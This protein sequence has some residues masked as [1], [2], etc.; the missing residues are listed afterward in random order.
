MVLL[1][2]GDVLFLVFRIGLAQRSSCVSALPLAICVIMATRFA[3]NVRDAFSFFY[4]L[5]LCDCASKSGKKMP[6]VLGA[7]YKMGWAFTPFGYATEIPVQGV[8]TDFIPP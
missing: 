1:L 8:A 2:C 5:G 6:L 7:T 4:P 3:P